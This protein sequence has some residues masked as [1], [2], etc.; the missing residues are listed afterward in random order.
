[1]PSTP[2]QVAPRC[3]QWLSPSLENS[4][5]SRSE[6]SRSP[7][8]RWSPACTSK[9]V[10]SRLLTRAS[11][12]APAGHGLYNPAARA[13][14]APDGA[15]PMTQSVR[16]R[17]RSRRARKPTQKWPIAWLTAECKSGC[18]RQA[19]VEIEKT[20]RQATRRVILR[21]SGWSKFAHWEH[22]F[23][24]HVKAWKFMALG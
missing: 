14:F 8:R 16:L 1:M 7:R 5:P 9:K 6:K 13:I 22:H 3:S 17:F 2:Y 11:R 24:G 21:P 4:F 10:P 20:I 12:E 19:T 23:V 18:S 15:M